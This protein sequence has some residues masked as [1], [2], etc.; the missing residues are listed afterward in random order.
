MRQIQN[1]IANILQEWSHERITKAKGI[2]A[3]KDAIASSNLSQSLMTF[4]VQVVGDTISIGIGFADNPKNQA[5]EYYKYVDEGVKG[6]GYASAHGVR[7][8]VITTGRFSY[9]TPYVSKKMVDSLQSWIAQKGIKVRTS[10]T[11]SSKNSVVPKSFTLAYIIAKNIKRS[12][13]GKTMFWSDT[14]NDKAYSD[15]A[16]MIG[17]AIGGSYTFTIKDI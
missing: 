5:D 9:K 17:E 3:S 13:I 15:L 4:D 10:K 2:L 12:G 11:E 1:E 6:I 14:F 16:D 7:K 8:S